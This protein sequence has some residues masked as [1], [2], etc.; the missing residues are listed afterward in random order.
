MLYPRPFPHTPIEPLEPRQLLALTPIPLGNHENVSHST[1]MSE[2]PSAA[3]FG[4]QLAA[5]WGERFDAEIRTNQKTIG[6]P[7][8]TTSDLIGGGVDAD[9]QF[10]DITYA[11]DGTLHAVFANDDGDVYHIRKLP[12][13]STWSNATRIAIDDYPNPLRIAST[14][15]GVLWIIWRNRD[16]TRLHWRRSENN[17][18]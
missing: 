4:N 18:L 6:S 9:T 16:G 7:W 3:T 17:G 1:D 11:P 14:T 12:G 15:D 2:G 8:P 10:P 13:S 5:V